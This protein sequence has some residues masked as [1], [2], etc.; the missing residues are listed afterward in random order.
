MSILNVAT[1]V[2]AHT[3]TFDYQVNDSSGAYVVADDYLEFDICQG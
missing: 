2:A 3:H 1:E